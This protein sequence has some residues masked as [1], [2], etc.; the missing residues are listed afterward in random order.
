MGEGREGSVL[1]GG[2]VGG[3]GGGIGGVG[4]GRG[5][6]AASLVGVHREEGKP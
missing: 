3:R 5:P 2:G 4:E 1:E 6:V